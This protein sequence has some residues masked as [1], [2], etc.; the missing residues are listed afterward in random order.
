MGKT[1]IKYGLERKIA[2]ALGELEAAQK[3]IAQIQA[4][5]KRMISLREKV[6][7]QQAL[8]S[9]RDILLLV[10]YFV[11]EPKGISAIRISHLLEISYKSAF[12]LL[13]KL[14]EVTTARQSSFLLSGEVEIDALHCGGYI[15]PGKDNPSRR[16]RRRLNRNREKA[17]VVMVARERYGRS[18]A[19]LVENESKM[20][21]ILPSV[22]EPGSMIFSDSFSGSSKIAAHYQ[23]FKVNHSKQY[24]DGWISTN[25][26]E[27]FF[28]RLRREELGI[29]H[30]IAGPYTLYY[31]NDACWREDNRR[32]DGQAKYLQVLSLAGAHPVSRIWKGYWQRRKEAA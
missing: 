13:H 11:N 30:K 8:I 22:V 25:H 24:A 6:R 28:S 7:E 5:L 20:P 12:V 19:F 31:A 2:Q 23:A 10:A 18:R 14:R 9:H 26:A 3:E 16:N 1:N 32:L 29:H 27:S 17:K 15:K 21:D 4:G